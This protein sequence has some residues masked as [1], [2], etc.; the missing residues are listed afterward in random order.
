MP[1]GRIE[2]ALNVRHLSR[3]PFLETSCNLFSI[4]DGSFKSFESFKV[5]VSAKE[6]KWTSLEFRTPPTFLETLISKYDFGPVKA[7]VHPNVREILVSL[8][9]G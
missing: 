2:R 3:G 1:L 8:K 5:K 6:T 4:P 7:G 9:R